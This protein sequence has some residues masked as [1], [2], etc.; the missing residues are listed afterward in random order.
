MITRIEITNFM[1]HVHTV[2]EPAAGL[3]VLVG[4]NNCGKSA[5]VAALQILCHNDASTYVLRHGERECSVK[6]ET[7]DGHTVEWRRKNAPSYLIDGQVFDRL[8]GSGLPEELHAAL[9]LPKVDAEGDADFD[10]HF[11]TQKAPIFLL[12]GSA[13]AARFFASSSDAIQLVQMQRRH[14]EKL[15]DANRMKNRL[16]AESKQLNAELETLEPVVDVEGRLAAATLLYDEVTRGATWLLEA[17]KQEAAIRAQAAMHARFAALADALRPVLPPPEMF[18]IEPLEERIAA[19]V[20][21]DNRLA[22][23]ASPAAALAG[24]QS[25]PDMARTDP[26][27]TLIAAIELE[28]G[29][30]HAGLSRCGALAAIQPPPALFDVASLAQSTESIVE[31]TE[32]VERCDEE[33]R[34]LAGLAGPPQLADVDSLDRLIERLA[35]CERER[36]V[37]Q[38]RSAAMGAIAEPPRPADEAELANLVAAIVRTTAQAAR[39][40][41][42]SALLA[43]TAAVPVPAETAPF[44]EFLKRLDDAAARVRT[45]EAAQRVA[46]S[47]LAAAAESLRTRAA[48][49]LCPVCGSPLDPDRVVAQAVAGLGSHGL[50]GHAH[51]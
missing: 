25:P 1:S 47:E 2:I 7:D 4:P 29:R 51:G 48:D 14:K 28:D 50:G 22:A 18:P 35:S 20:N 44:A 31:L 41:D 40:Q 26:L 10:I 3:T 21:A 34:S 15:A 45:C 38:R 11:G 46:E 30:R 36:G 42:A 17:E 19:I 32:R 12:G 9:R 24:L 49:K 33:R 5:V 8:R 27:E 6:I 13:A 39:W 43:A 37:A 23:T 16:E